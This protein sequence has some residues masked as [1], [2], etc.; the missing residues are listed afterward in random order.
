[1]LVVIIWETNQ[2][3][4][5][6]T[7]KQK[8]KKQKNPPKKQKQKQASK[9]TKTKQNKKQK[10]RA[11]EMVQSVTCLVAQEWGLEFGPSAPF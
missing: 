8:T 9:Q 4:K 2:Q 10:R 3:T 1:M 7:K 11:V 5:A 6:K